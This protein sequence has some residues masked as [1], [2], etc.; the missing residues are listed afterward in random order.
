MPSDLYCHQSFGS[1]REKR[2]SWQS[3][4]TAST[5]HR[6]KANRAEQAHYGLTSL[7]SVLVDCSRYRYS[8][9]KVFCRQSPY[10]VTKPQ[11]IQVRETGIKKLQCHTKDFCLFTS[12]QRFRFKGESFVLFF[13]LGVL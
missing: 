2:N 5:R 13:C 3:L 6:V 8:I 10:T 4:A 1:T 11:N 9:L 12:L 7:R